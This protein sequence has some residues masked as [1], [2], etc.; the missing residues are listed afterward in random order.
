MRLI[1]TTFEDAWLVE[2]E[3]HEDERGFF[4]RT[5]CQKEFLELGLNS[6]FVQCNVSFNRR[7][8]TLRGL[9]Y[10]VP[11]HEEV[12]LVRCTRGSIFDVIVDIRAE[13]ETYGQYAAF[14]LSADNHLALY[15][16]RGFA[17]GFQSLA[18]DTEVLYQMSDFFDAE[19]ARGF[20]YAD[21]TIAIRWPLPVSVISKNDES[22]GQFAA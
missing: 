15:I 20:H 16:P 19:S 1:P 7:A 13:S 22:L 14:E 18:A 2:P 3:L 21:A 6:Q 11:P 17:H 10:Q 12:K 4:A 9:H 8:G 5:W